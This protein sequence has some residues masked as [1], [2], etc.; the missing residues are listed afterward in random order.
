MITDGRSPQPNRFDRVMKSPASKSISRAP[1][2]QRA[3]IKRA[4]DGG[5]QRDD[6]RY[7]AGQPSLQK[8]WGRIHLLGLWKNTHAFTFFGLKLGT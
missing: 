2:L 1:S 6:V 8:K 7:V 4:A 5:A 3:A